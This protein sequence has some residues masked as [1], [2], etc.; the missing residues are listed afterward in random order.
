M[1]AGG[2]S[3]DAL[4]PD[5]LDPPV[6]D[7]P[8]LA[9]PAP[10]PDG[11]AKACAPE[12]PRLGAVEIYA[13]PDAGE[14]PLVDVLK[15]ARTSI[16]MFIYLMGYGGILDTLQAKAKAGV[17]VR[18]IMDVG[19]TAN[20]KYKDA[21]T[22]AGAEVIW[23]DPKF[24]YM[25]AKTFVVDGTEAVISSGNYSLSLSIQRERNFVVHLVD[26]DDVADISAMFAA[27]WARQDPDM[28]CTRLIVSPVN[29]KQ[30]VIDFL[31]SATKSLVI[32][33]M[34]FADQDVRATVAARKAAGVDVRVLLAAPSW[35][36][37]NTDAATFLKGQSIPV[38]WMSTPGVHVKAA[39][40]D[41]ARAWTGSTN[42]SYTSLAKNREIS[43]I[44][45][46]APDA[47]KVMT[48][49][50]ETDWAKSTAF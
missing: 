44:V 3:V 10:R 21:L 30:R 15:R 27:D 17:K 34:Q 8:D 13:L 42:L 38:R 28:S 20:Q 31:Q 36:D 2:C 43:V 32:E 50:F 33:S 18:V 40:V 9:Q 39:V 25:H 7:P 22:A 49:A 35:I 14:A 11:A 48:D 19:Q 26:P 5:D 23:S 29:A 4:A 1:L 47:V 37:T 45:S 46:N 12:D 6:G 24:P 16:D 41:G